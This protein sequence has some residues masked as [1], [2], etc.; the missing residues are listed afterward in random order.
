MKSVL[1][2]EDDS[3]K[4]DAIQSL[5]KSIKSDTEFI[6]STSVANAV[7]AIKD[8]LFDLIILDMA[9]PSHPVVA[10]GGAPLSWLTGGMEILFELQSLERS[11]NCVIITQYPDIE[12]CGELYPV[13]K[14]AKAIFENYGIYVQSCLE[15]SQTS[16]AWRVA[17]AKIFN[18]L[19][20]S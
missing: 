17:L 16:Q 4:S 2:V 18:K 14:A 9:L 15:Y 3:F 10:G 7:D 6:L 19:C 8:T 12:I 1:L 20:E 11:D 5:L 13:E